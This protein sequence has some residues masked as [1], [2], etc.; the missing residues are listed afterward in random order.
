MLGTGDIGVRGD[1]NEGVSVRLKPKALACFNLLA[2]LCCDFLK[3]LINFACFLRISRSLGDVAT[4]IRTS[5]NEPTSC[6]LARASSD[7]VFMIFSQI[8]FSESRKGECIPGR[9]LS[10]ETLGNITD[11]VRPA[12]TLLDTGVVTKEVVE[13]MVAGLM[14]DWTANESKTFDSETRVVET[15]SFGG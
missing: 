7:C 13:R 8:D 10:V 3:L 14:G 9:A 11:D 4:L 12:T 6:V 1:E 15:G 2:S 5:Y